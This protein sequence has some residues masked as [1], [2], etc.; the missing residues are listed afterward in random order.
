MKDSV[1]FPAYILEKKEYQVRSG[2]KYWNKNKT[3]TSRYETREEAQSCCDRL[4]KSTDL[5]TFN[6]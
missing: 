5:K 6:S 3:G 2:S 4:N 1:Y